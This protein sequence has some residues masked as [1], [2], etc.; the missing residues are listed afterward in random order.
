MERLKIRRFFLV[1]A[2]LTP[3]KGYLSYPIYVSSMSDNEELEYSNELDC[4][5]DIAMWGMPQWRG[6]KPPKTL[7]INLTIFSYFPI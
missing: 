2:H 4:P 5:W 6:A 7:L 1:I 3:L